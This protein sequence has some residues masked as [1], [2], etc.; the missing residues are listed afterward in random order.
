MF[1]GKKDAGFEPD[2]GTGI[3]SPDCRG[4]GPSAGED[5]WETTSFDA[6]V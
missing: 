2:L 6:D 5:C 1:D 3:V 4:A